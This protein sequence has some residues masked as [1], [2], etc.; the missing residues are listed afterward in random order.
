[1]RLARTV[2]LLGIAASFG[3][4]VAACNKDKP[5]A[6][7][8]KKA[9]ATPVPSGLVFND[10][11]PTTGNATGLGVRGD[12][13]LEGGLA[14]VAGGEPG[15]LAPGAAPGEAAE[16]LKVTEPGA[17]PRTARKY[18]F[19]TNRTDKR[20]LTIS[21]NVTQ[22][23]GGQTAP[24]QEIT[25]KLSLDLTP[26]Q[27]KPAGA[28]IEAKLTKVEL[29]GAPAQVAGMLASLNGLTATFDVTS[30]G[31]VGEL[32]FAGTQQMKNQLAETVLQGLSQAA[33]LLV[34][35]FPDGPV[36]V[37][38]K[39]E[40]AAA[41]SEQGEQGT[42]RFTLKEVSNDSAVV[43]ADIEIKVPR[44][45]QQSQRGGMMFVEVD[46]KGHYTYQSRFDR[47]SPK[48][49]GELTLN[50]KIEASDPKGGGKQQ[51]TQT[52]KAKH[53]IETPGGGAK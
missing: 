6:E 35:P 8:S 39:W 52:Q 34:A 38:A 36:G 33:Q 13:G 18:T 46:G 44:R 11:L 10:F 45:A 28:S 25:L 48:V 15:Q 17:E 26:K 5:A 3:I 21:Q 43:E 53:L 40:V 37:G 51:V 20:I 42:K 14:A 29:P 7:E 27:V 16:K 49:E 30:H 12:A 4:F 32:S 31:E 47:M 41:K 19:V 2:S 9:E 50:E 24:G 1:M 22:S 23:A